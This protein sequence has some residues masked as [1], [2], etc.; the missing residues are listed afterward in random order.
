MEDNN[1]FLSLKSMPMAVR[2]ISINK[3]KIKMK[4]IYW[5]LF[6]F[7]V[8]VSCTSNKSDSELCTRIDLNSSYDEVSVFDL[9][10]DIEFIPLETNDSSVL[11][12]V[13]RY[14]VWND[15]I[16][17][18]DRKQ[19]DIFM[20]KMNGDFIKRL[21][22]KGN[23]PGEYVRI[24]DMNINR[25]TGNLEVLSADGKILIY[26]SDGSKYLSQI[27]FPSYFIHSF[28]NLSPDVDV[29]YFD[30]V[31]TDVLQLYSRKEKKVIASAWKI[32][33]AL[34]FTGFLPSKPFYIYN[35]SLYLYKGYSGETFSISTQSPVLH[36]HHSW[37]FGEHTFDVSSIPANENFMY[38][39]NIYMKGSAKQA[40]GFICTEN[41]KYYIMLF[42]YKNED[43]I[44]FYNKM[45]KTVKLFHNFSEGFGL[46]FNYVDNEYMIFICP[47]GYQDKFISADVLDEKN[48]K[49]LS[50][51]NE[52]SNPFVIR[53]KFK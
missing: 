31:E 44:L 32:P 15:T 1:P 14:T 9:F 49:R 46:R 47:H 37:D 51:M 4:N 53:L 26:D 3:N 50:S 8:T 33:K 21:S 39:H 28:Q 19:D 18:F 20:F 24:E 34:S 2:S 17:I 5:G 52:E 45:D 42:R 7:I 16:Y 30:N 43:K 40:L 36:P 38:Y 10:S 12:Y 29:L 25:F 6:I 22:R 48:R 11:S 13:S 27:E 41:D 23:G 35:D